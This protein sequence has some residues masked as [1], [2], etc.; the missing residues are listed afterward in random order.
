MV[1]NEPKNRGLSADES[2]KPASAA[3]VTQA[4]LVRRPRKVRG[5]MFGPLEIGALGV[6]AIALGAVIVLYI[7]FVAPSNSTLARNRLEA[8]RLEAELISAKTKY[9]EI[10]T[11]EEQ[12]ARLLTSVDDF[13]TRFLPPAANGRTSL[14]QRINGLIAAYGLTNTAGPDYQP[15]GTGEDRKDEQTEAERGRAK[16]RSLFPGIYISMTV[17]GPYQN[18]RRFIRDIETGNEFI[19]ISTIELE[20]SDSEQKKRET[21]APPAGQVAGNPTDPTVGGSVA[22]NSQS[23][24]ITRPKGKTRGEVVALRLE[25]AAYF[26]RA[27][28]VP[29]AEH[30]T[31][32]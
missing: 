29:I 6:G 24:G 10:T 23:P 7:V 21:G 8:N 17:E 22:V 1:S 11:T 15:L 32:Q 14:Y 4:V 3:V 13:E 9:G 12:V 26:R 5:G 25:M 27:N 20:P 30:P 18:L 19:T 28:Y 16:F 31:G 2:A